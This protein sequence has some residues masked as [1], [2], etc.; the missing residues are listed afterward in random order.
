M[1]PNE[2][3]A[4]WCVLKD[5]APVEWK[6]ALVRT[7]DEVDLSALPP[8][9]QAS[10]ASDSQK[11]GWAAALTVAQAA[12]PTYDATPSAW[13]RVPLLAQSGTASGLR[14][15]GR[16]IES[17]DG[18]R[19]HLDDRGRPHLSSRPDQPMEPLVPDVVIVDEIKVAQAARR[20]GRD[21]ELVERGTGRKVSVKK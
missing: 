20:L 6:W 18:V 5:G 11:I 7:P 14:L 21:L 4:I 10:K 2:P 12:D 17:D 16:A 19:Y 8:E 9:V 13:R 3:R 1:N 15:V